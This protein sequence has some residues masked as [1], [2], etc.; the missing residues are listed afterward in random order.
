MS[1]APQKELYYIA[2]MRL[3]TERAH[4]FQ[5]MRM[6]AAFV[7]CGLKV[8]LIVPRRHTVHADDP[9]LFYHIPKIFSVTRV[10]SLD[11]FPFRFIPRRI[12]F[13]VNALTFSFSLLFRVR[14]LKN[15]YVFSRDQVSAI[16]LHWFCPRFC[17]E[18]H[19]A[20]AKNLRNQFILR[21]LK[22]IVVTNAIKYEKLIKLFGVHAPRIFVAHHGVDALQ[23]AP[24]ASKNECRMQLGFLQEKKYVLYTGHLFDWKGVYTLARASLFLPPDY[25]IV[26]VGGTSE[27]LKKFN[28]FLFQEKLTNVSALGFMHHE[29]IPVY[30]SAADVLVIPTSQRFEIGSQESSPLKL[31]EYMASGKPIVASHIPALAEVVTEK[32][33]YFV[34][35]DNAKALSQGIVE[36]FHDP[37]KCAIAAQE[38]VQHQ[39]WESRAK[40]IINFLNS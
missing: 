1:A 3:P 37:R 39:S 23:F 18:L 26:L 19:D 4:G 14:T 17:L 9:F 21:V 6:C 31:F 22:K 25:T 5:V 7:A 36:A 10:W 8:T 24:P 30:L 27:D 11:L 16:F 2:P 29:K 20:P 32:E 40:N 33:V 34:P 35:P 13:W 28:A 12:C 38:Q 15:A